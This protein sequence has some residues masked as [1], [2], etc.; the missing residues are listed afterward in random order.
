[1]ST[2]LLFAGH[3]TTVVQI[4]LQTVILL[5]D[6]DL[7][8]PLVQD[9]TLIPQAVEEML[10]IT[11]VGGGIGGLPRYARTDFEINAVPIHT[12]DLVLLDMGAANHDPAV[13]PDSDRAHIGR[14]NAPHVTFGYGARFCIGA[15]LARIELKTV[16]TQLIPRFPLMRLVRDPTTLIVRDEVLAGR[17][18]RIAGVMVRHFPL[19]GWP[20]TFAFPADLESV[21]LTVCSVGAV[22]PRLALRLFTCCFAR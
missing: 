13:F 19:A 3:E 5:T 14:K 20:T 15:P 9:P 11:T 21:H 2:A 16:F 1:M 6:P 4:G 17:T 8:R 18:R 12:G 22:M 7:W 10:R